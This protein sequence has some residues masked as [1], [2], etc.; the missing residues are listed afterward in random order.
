[1][2]APAAWGWAAVAA[3]AGAAV[4]AVVAMVATSP[5]DAATSRPRR[6]LGEAAASVTAANTLRRG[7]RCLA[8]T[9]N[10]VPLHACGVSCRVRAESARILADLYPK[11]RGPCVVPPLLSCCFVWP[12]HTDRIRLCDRRSGGGFRM[13]YRD[14][15]TVTAIV[16][17]R[18]RL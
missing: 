18:L 7:A 3:S 5:E 2:V 6:A 11:G 14:Y 17:F 8:V 1:M 12:D 13:Q 10:V 9:V 4:A 16:T 15:K